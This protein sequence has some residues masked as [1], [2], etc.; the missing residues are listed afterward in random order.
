MTTEALF[1]FHA[2]LMSPA[3]P[4]VNHLYRTGYRG[5]RVL[6]KEGEHFKAALQQVVVEECMALPWKM[7]IDAVYLEAA[8][9]RLTIG[10]NT[11]ILNGSWK[12]GR[13]TEKGN[14]QSPYKRLDASNYIKVIEDAIAKGTG[15]DDSVHLHVSIVKLPSSSTHLEVAYEVLPKEGSCLQTSLH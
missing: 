14:P 15:I 10:F 13:R 2:V 12:P 1:S 6:T 5:S 7:A 11:Q 3:P 9:V 8:W 4:S